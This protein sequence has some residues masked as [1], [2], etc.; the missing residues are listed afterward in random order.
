MCWCTQRFFMYVFRFLSML[1]S[2][3][4]HH[5]YPANVHKPHLPSQRAYTTPTQPTCISHTYP[6]TA[7]ELLSGA[8][9][10][11]LVHLHNRKVGHTQPP[12]ISLKPVVFTFDDA[13]VSVVG[14]SGK[15]GR[16]SFS[17]GVHPT[18]AQLVGHN[19]D[20]LSTYHWLTAKRE[21]K[22]TVSRQLRCLES[23]RMCPWLGS[24][25]IVI[26]K[27]GR[28]FAPN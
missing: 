23:C 27:F 4:I 22:L 26:A 6:A 11:S 17:R 28:Y 12:V 18:Y 10:Q 8:F 16:T 15:S 21:R 1:C 5:T 19:L 24:G 3:C 20:G 2:A 9:F 13:G 14:E 7:S 25:S